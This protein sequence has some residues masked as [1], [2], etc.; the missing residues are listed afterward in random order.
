[1][2]RIDLRI[3]ELA[4]FF[5]APVQRL[6]IGP[7]C[8]AG[9]LCFMFTFLWFAQ[10]VRSGWCNDESAHIPAG[11]YHL[12]TGRME[13]YRVNPPLPRMIAAM[14]L[15]ANRPDIQWKTY[16]SPYTRSEY[17]FAEV[18]ASQTQSELRRQLLWSRSTVLLFFALGLWSIWRWTDTLYGRSAAWLAT[19]MWLVS[20]DI[21][22]YSAVVAP[23]LPAAG[24]GLFC[25]Y[26]FWCWL[27]KSQRPFPWIVAATVALAMLCKF[28]WLYLFLFLPTITLTHDTAKWFKRRSEVRQSPA[29]WLGQDTAN[30]ILSFLLTLLIINGVYGF[31]GS[32]TWLG[33]YEFISTSLAGSELPRGEV[34]NRFSAGPLGDIPVPLPKQMVL[35]LDYLRWEFERGM[36]CYL[37]GVWQDRGWWYFY[38]YAMAVKIPLGFLALIAIGAISLVA[39]IFRRRTRSDQEWLPLLIA[40]SFVA[41][42]SSQTGFTHHV[43]YVLPAF[44]FLFIVA[45]RTLVVLPERVGKVAAVA[46]LSGAV[47]Y[48]LMHPGLSHSFFNGFAGGPNNGWRH[49]GLSNVDWGQST[50]RMVDWIANH[51]EKRPLTVLFHSRRGEPDRLVDDFK[52][53]STELHLQTRINPLSVRPATPGWF[54]LSS[55]Q[56]TLNENRYFREQEI[57]DQP[58]PDMILFH[59]TTEDWSEVK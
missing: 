5:R 7:A 20:P 4:S 35:G 26:H 28:S 37:N 22:T 42:V 59:I 34:G 2:A 47:S 3:H 58:Y 51:P 23:D 1:M 11:L 46:L 52:D 38:L 31:D 45:S 21:I 8:A 30:L 54:L 43:R 16:S 32:F 15:L 53:V 50:W 29:T 10:V 57:I 39:D 40:V 49:L 13:A 44:G 36:P 56:L 18:W 55:H 6:D 17:E 41:L 24:S 12:E 33:D 48:Q 27:R 9:A 14:P 19:A 25:G